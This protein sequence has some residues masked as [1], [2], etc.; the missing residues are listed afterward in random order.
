MWSG[1]L[2]DPAGADYN[3]AVTSTRLNASAPS[4]PRWRVGALPFLNAVPLIHG[5]DADPGIKLHR[6]PP[7]QL[8]D[9]LDAG[10]LDAA[11][12][13]SIDY[14]RSGRDWLILPAPVIASAGPILTVRVFS[15]L[16]FDQLTA[17]A[18]DPDS[19]TS[20]V[21]AQ[22]LWR[23]VYRRGLSVAPLVRDPAGPRRASAI[24]LIG[25]KVIP[26]LG[27]WPYELDLGQAWTHCTRL[28]FVYA[29]WGVCADPAGD[30]DPLVARLRRARASAAAQLDRL[31]DGHGPRHGFTPPLARRYL[32]ENLLY[33]P[34]PRLW[35][36]LERFFDLA[37]QL[38]LMPRR[39]PLRF[40][41]YSPA[42]VPRPRRAAC[43]SV[44]A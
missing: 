2:F 41:S 35:Q 38:H 39:R 40:H 9:A 32:R 33:D 16:P 1:N 15:R 25:D 27:R 5:L 22:V 26:Q 8:A 21:L 31:A 36:G 19:H 34:D 28:P 11:L 17:L 12:V 3:S 29:F 42:D 6:L 44:D 13:P 30:W 23:L 37:D 7:A 18:C 14:Q 10:R 20:V 43:P 4:P 24:L